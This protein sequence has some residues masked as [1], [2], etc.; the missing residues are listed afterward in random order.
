M[1][2]RSFVSVVLVVTFVSAV[3]FRSFRF[4]GFVLAFRV[5]VHAQLNIKR[6]LPW[7]HSVNLILFHFLKLRIGQ[8]S[9]QIITYIYTSISTMFILYIPKV[10][11]TRTF[12]TTTQ[13]FHPVLYRVI[14][15]GNETNGLETRIGNT[16]SKFTAIHRPWRKLRGGICRCKTF[17]LRIFAR[18][19]LLRFRYCS[20]HIKM[21]VLLTYSARN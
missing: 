15:V 8:I 9:T 16:F 18:R 19:T 17:F 21:C 7:H 1:I 3:S 14:A 10:Q 11:R 6:I 4:D 13:R 2:H 12:T 20:I 5:L